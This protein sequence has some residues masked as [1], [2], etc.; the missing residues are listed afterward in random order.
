MIDDGSRVR[1]RGLFGRDVLQDRR[2]KGV[3]LD[4]PPAKL[5]S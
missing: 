2:K 4:R 5:F 3:L 1:T